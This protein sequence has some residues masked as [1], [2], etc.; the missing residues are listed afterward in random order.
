MISLSNNSKFFAFKLV[1]TRLII[2]KKFLTISKIDRVALKNSL[3]RINSKE[4]PRGVYKRL[5]YFYILAKF[6]IVNIYKN[7]LSI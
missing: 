3:K 5:K 2:I 7:S 1:E 4:K 6:L